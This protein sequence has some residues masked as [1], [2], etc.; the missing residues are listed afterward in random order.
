MLKTAVVTDQW[1]EASWQ[2]FFQLTRDCD[3][4]K[5]K[6][7]Y[8]A[9]W[10]KI[11]MAPV[12]M[13]HSQDNSIISTVIVLYTSLKNIAVQEFTNGSYRQIGYQ[14]V[15]PDISYYL[16]HPLPQLPRNNTPIDLDKFPPSSLVVEIG[17]SSYLEDLDKKRRLYEKLGIQEYWVV[18]VTTVKIRAFRISKETSQE[19]RESQV[20]LGLSLSLVEEALQRSSQED[21]GSIT[22]WLIATF[23]KS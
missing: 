9:G 2:D 12:G 4:Q 7:Y 13:A 22:R 15:Q 16:G 21:H 20:L 1:M 18:N 11:E 23:S 8:F 6:F 17:S 5:G 3:Y 10:M 14:E 19:I